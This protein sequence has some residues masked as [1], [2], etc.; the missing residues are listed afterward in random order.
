MTNLVQR[1]LSFAFVASLL[2]LV[3]LPVIGGTAAG[4][5]TP[6]AT[7]SVA[8]DQ[9]VTFEPTTV[10]DILG[11]QSVDFTNTGTTTVTGFTIGGRRP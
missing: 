10:G 11:P 3:A 2:A 5:S 1:P 8:G 7:S 6:A 4:A 9:S